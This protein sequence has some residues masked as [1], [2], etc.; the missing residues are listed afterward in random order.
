MALHDGK[1]LDDDL[2]RRADE[3]LALAAAL[4]IDNVVEGVVLPSPSAPASPRPNQNNTH[5]DGNAN[6]LEVLTNGDG[7]G[8]EQPGC[9]RKRTNRGVST[10]WP[11]PSVALRKSHE[12]R[13]AARV[14]ALRPAATVA[15]A[16]PPRETWQSAGSEGRLQCRPRRA[17]GGHVP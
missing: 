7:R 2:G 15:A 3:H 1:E 4:G 9:A 5:K 6:H 10:P 16:T 14:G 8:G 12:S 17:L 13:R 11:R